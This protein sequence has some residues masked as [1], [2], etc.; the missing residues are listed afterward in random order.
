ME[1][2]RVKIILVDD[3]LVYLEGVVRYLSGL[4][5][6][7]IVGVFTRPGEALDLIS[8]MPCDVLFTDMRMEVMNG[9]ALI[10]KAKKVQQDLKT[11]V[12]TY[13]DNLA[14]LKVG[15]STYKID[16]YSGKELMLSDF[17]KIL[18]DVYYNNKTYISPRMKEQL[19]SN[20]Q[21]G[22]FWKKVNLT[23]REIEILLLIAAE[24]ESTVIAQEL[25]I[26]I[27][28]VNNHR[29]S[30]LAKTNSKN[31]VGAIDYARK[32]GLL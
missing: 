16:G 21:N 8:I 3:H 12:I 32:N 25:G 6:V 19:Y 2:K 11:V 29:K 1:K 24:K 20:L 26:S 22:T 30:I 18:E 15:L 28:T 4:G 23:Q 13:E 5:Y 14:S 10:K 17:Q 27:H 7:D 31:A 9:Y